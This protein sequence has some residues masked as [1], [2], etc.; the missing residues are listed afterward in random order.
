[1]NTFFI[2]FTIVIAIELFLMIEI[3]STIGALNTVAL[4]FIT[5]IIGIYYAKFQGIRTLKSGIINL[6]QNK[7]TIYELLSGASIALAAV[8]L[9]VP[10]F[11]TDLIGLFFLIPITRNVLLRIIFKNKNVNNKKNENILDG[12]IVDNNK[13]DL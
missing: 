8:L 2:F 9:I 11:L 7:I 6:Y 10:G 12:E 13:D 3:G 1:M 4:I 5:A